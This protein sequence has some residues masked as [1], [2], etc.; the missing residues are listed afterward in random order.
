[1]S[2]APKPDLPP[3]GFAENLSDAERIELGSF[4]DFITANDGDTI[5]EEGHEQDSLFLV[6][7]G[8]LHV[9]TE[10][11]GRSVLLGTVKSGDTIGEVNIF[12]PGKASASVVAK[13]LSQIWKI[14]RNRLADFIKAHPEPASRLLYNVATQLSRRLRRTNEKVAMA[15]EAMLDSF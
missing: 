2:D 1:M 4:G 10:T 15:R 13:A 6:I 14:D 11:T 5:I 8:R 9:Q 3:M 7:F 12:D